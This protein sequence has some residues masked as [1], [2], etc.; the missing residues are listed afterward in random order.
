MAKDEPV[1]LAFLSIY[2]THPSFYPAL[3]RALGRALIAAPETALDAYIETAPLSAPCDLKDRQQV[4]YCLEV[5]RAG[6]DV[7]RRRLM[8]TKAFQRWREWDF[9]APRGYLAKP[10]L[11]ELD[12]AVLGYVKESVDT[13]DCTAEQESIETKLT[14]LECTWFP[15]ITDLTTARNRLI[16][17]FQPYAH[18]MRGN[19]E[20]NWLAESPNYQPSGSDTL[21][22][23]LRFS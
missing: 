12:F 14:F 3:Q 10:T 23:S 17:R 16:S 8:W 18:A 6:T 20:E 1:W 22:A 21:Y 4:A 19:T 7:A 5:F 11:S 2:N 9:E 15:T 13:K